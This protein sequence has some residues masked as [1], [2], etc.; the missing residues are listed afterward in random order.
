MVDQIWLERMKKLGL[1]G[2]I[3]HTDS[4]EQ[5]MDIP[6]S[7][8]WEEAVRGERGLKNRLKMA[9]LGAFKSI[10]D[11]DWSFPSKCDRLQIE[12]L[13]KVNF[14]QES[15]NLVILGPNGAGKSMIACNILYQAILQ[16]HTALFVTASQMLN[17]LQSQDGTQNLNRRLKYYSTPSIIN[18]D[19]VGYLS[20]SNAHADLLFEV[21][22]RRYQK[23]STIITTNKPFVEWD[24]IFPNASCVVS[25]IDRL[26]HH[27]E[28]VPIEVEFS[29][30]LK[31]AQERSSKRQE[32]RAKNKGTLNKPRS[33][34]VQASIPDTEIAPDVSR[35]IVDETAML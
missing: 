7:V 25:L 34:E 31:E 9:K 32:T 35:D 27:S 19:E 24:Q 5:T 23:K 16:G 8:Q 10:A 22:S 17:D 4:I 13:L 28:M 21:I 14:M 20:Y 30:R 15:M 2:L 12:E 33:V 6:T 29:Y 1:F 26:I 3:V 18:I 11:F